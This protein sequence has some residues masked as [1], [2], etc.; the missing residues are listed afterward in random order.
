M[1]T[2]TNR[3]ILAII[4]AKQLYKWLWLNSNYPFYMGS[5][6]Q[7]N[8]KGLPHHFG[9]KKKTLDNYFSQLFYSVY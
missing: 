5:V 2:N 4:A 8:R 9:E 6:F 3:L 7:L 1:H